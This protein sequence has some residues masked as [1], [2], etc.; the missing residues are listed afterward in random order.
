MTDAEVE[1]CRRDSAFLRSIV[2]DQVD[3]K[4][5][6]KRWKGL[7]PF[8]DDSTPSFFV[9]E[10]GGFK[11]FGCGASGTVFD[12]IMLRDR[13][14]FRRA[15]EI[16][17]AER[18][19][20]SPK[21][22]PA[23]GNGGD[24]DEVWFPGKPPPG[25]K[26]DQRKL[27]CDML[28]EYYDAS[29]QLICYVRRF[30]ER[31][32]RRK[33]FLPLTY[34]TLTKDG[35]TVTGWHD[36]APAV[37]R[38]LYRLNAL[39]HSPADAV[40]LLCEGEKAA[41]AAQRMFP[42]YV[43]MTWMGGAAADRTADLAPLM[44]RT[45]IIW[46]DA[47]K[48]GGDAAVRLLER[49]PGARMLDT[50]DL[51]DAYDAADLERDG[52][53]HPDEW[54]ESR[55]S[56]PEKPDNSTKPDADGLEIWDAGEDD[57]KIPPREW[58]LGNVFC[59]RFLSALIADGG[60]GKTALRIAQLISLAIGRSLTGEH[61]FCRCR[62]L[63]VSL[64]DDKDELRRRVYA[65]LRHHGIAP[66]EARG[67]LYLWAPK[68]LRLAEVK[69]KGPAEGPLKL[70]I[71]KAIDK[72][73]IDLVSLDP[74]IKSHG[75]EENNNMQIDYVCTVL[76]KM[77][78]NENVAIDLPHHTNKTPAPAGDANRSRGASSM[79]DAAR[80]VYTLTPM[81]PDEAKTF[82]LSEAE[83]RSLVRMDSGKVNITPPASEAKW[84]RIVGVPLGNGAGIYPAGDCVQTVEQ[85][86]PPNTWAGLESALLNRILDEIEA[87]RPDGSR[88]S[89]A[90]SATGR[91]A[92]RVVAAH[93]PDKT[94]QQ[95]REVIKTWVKSGTLRIEEY[96]DPVAR[97]TLQGLCVN[98][99]QRPS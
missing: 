3:L 50:A 87:G 53:D 99:M 45:V 9:F 59:R 52:H 35:H 4:R 12:F 58:L 11:C 72:H 16:I 55:L 66:Y 78:I 92:W 70:A 33:Q 95:A 84:F 36:R 79:K 2:A 13:V 5:E 32:G 30:E 37:P 34:G 24:H 47:D 21:P 83:R 93:A 17:A 22:K 27:V 96:D 18:G 74:F 38:A 23:N 73:K 63:I 46:P 62:V 48:A 64:E 42:D 8:H 15:A 26:P 81:S 20:R 85:W 61:V 94:E 69:D 97:K 68:G 40:V 98:P 6:G 60:V 25:D 57:Y 67:W 86:T 71:E 75:M 91:A 1:Q 88:Y 44:G 41:E 39:S 90:G 80:L 29:D 28:H 31:N 10:D 56:S 89:V 7:C 43:A 77:A 65:V 54:L 19:L 76:T 49:L 82:G 51:P 14:D